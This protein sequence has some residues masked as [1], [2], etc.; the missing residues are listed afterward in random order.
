MALSDSMSSSIQGIKSQSSAMSAVADNVANM[1]TVSYKEARNKFA[2]LVT[3]SF[4]AGGYQAGG[5]KN[6]VM[7]MVDQG[8]ALETSN[9]QTA[10]AIQGKGMFVVGSNTTPQATQMFSRAGDFAPDNQGYLKNTAGS[11]LQGWAVDSSGNVIANT[12][13]LNDLVPIQLQS[14]TNQAT[15]TKNMSLALNLSSESAVDA[16]FTVT[17]TVYDSLG[18]TK[19]I[20]LAFTKKQDN[21]QSWY[22]TATTANGTITQS[23]TSNAYENIEIQFDTAGRPSSFNTTTDHDGNIVTSTSLPGLAIAWSHDPATVNAS[24]ISLNLGSVGEFNGLTCLAGPNNVFSRA[25]DGTPAGELVAYNIDSTGMMRAY[26]DNQTSKPVYQIPLA[27]FPNPRGLTAI[28]GNNYLASLQ[29]GDFVLQQPQNDGAGAILSGNLESSTVDV[30]TE[31]SE[32]VSTQ[33]AFSANVQAFQTEDEM[34]R[35]L[36]RL[37]S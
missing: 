3:S 12:G 30:T 6:V 25:Q 7:R 32:M 23:G 36:E 8:G 33:Q 28:S 24:A 11:Y 17:Q 14:W 37:R 35:I 9:S 2:T 22:L 21:P 34:Y 5:V 16:T 29:A 31:F 1:R 20:Q 19:D 26:F 13:T 15:A 27:I 18:A 10:L 4:T